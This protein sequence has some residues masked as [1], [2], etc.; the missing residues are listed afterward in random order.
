MGFVYLI[1]IIW[2]S[3][4]FLFCIESWI[5]KWYTYTNCLYVCLSCNYSNVLRYLG[6]SVFF[7]SAIRDLKEYW[8]FITLIALANWEEVMHFSLLKYPSSL[9]CNLH[10][11]FSLMKIDRTW[12]STCINM[13]IILCKCMCM[14]FHTFVYDGFTI[15]R[16][17]FKI[18]ETKR[19]YRKN[20]LK[21]TI[22]IH[23]R[24]NVALF[25][26]WEIR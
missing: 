24:G 25:Q 3:L 19:K 11:T 5:D 15:S 14:C 22:I 10:Q 18:N 26:V 16:F 2:L 20:V 21:I 8:N 17:L 13:V 9:F 6:K 1:T 4:H 7:M 12:R 23:K